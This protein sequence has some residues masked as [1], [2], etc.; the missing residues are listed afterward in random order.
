MQISYDPAKRDQTLALRGID[1]ADAGEVLTGLC[2]TVEDER[3]DYGETRLISVGYL[4]GRMVV[5]VW[6]PRDDGARII[7]IRKA[8][9]R[10]IERYAP[11]LR[12][13]VG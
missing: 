1:M 12:S 2:V 9:D 4:R 3:F 13:N 6:T 8:N 10:E 7:S 5:I 11:A